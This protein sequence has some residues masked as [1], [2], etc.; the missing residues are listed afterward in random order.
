MWQKL[1]QLQFAPNPGEVLRWMVEAGRRAD[2]ARLW[3]RSAPGLCRL[4]R[5]PAHDHPLDGALRRDER[6][7]RATPCC[8]R[9]CATPPSPRSARLLFVHAGVDRDARSPR[10]ATRSGGAATTSSISPLR[11]PAS[12]ASS[13]ASTAS[14]AGWSNASSPCRSMAAPAAAA[15]CSRPAS[16]PDGDGSRPARGLSGPPGWSGSDRGVAAVD[17][18]VAAGDKAGPVAGEKHRRRRRSPAG[19]PSRPQML[20]AERFARCLEA[21]VAAQRSARSR[22]RPATR[23]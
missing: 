3:R 6:G 5:R 7:P 14:T 4:P 15:G 21:A 10:K 23:C 18:Q 22:P 11:S 13:R 2:R 9:R 12:A 17:E 8:S 16:P 20:W 1:L 19:W